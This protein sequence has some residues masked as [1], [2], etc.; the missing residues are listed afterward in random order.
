MA[1]GPMMPIVCPQLNSHQTLCH[2][3][4]AGVCLESLYT[5]LMAIKM[6]LYHINL[7]NEKEPS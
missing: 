6:T 5:L 3:R 7:Y 1:F 4:G 2:E